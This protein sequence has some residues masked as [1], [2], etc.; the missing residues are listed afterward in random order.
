[1]EIGLALSGGGVRAAAFHLGVLRRLAVEDRFEAVAQISTVSGGSLLI[2]T[3]LAMSNGQWPS[4]S[5]YGRKLFPA[6]RKLLTRTDL[7]SLRAVGW[8]GLMKYNV[9]LVHRRAH[10]LADLLERRWG[11]QGTLRDLWWI[12]ATCLETGKNW[13][14]S[15]REMGDWKFG[16]HYDPRIRI[17]DAAA[18]VGCR[19]LCDW[20]ADAKASPGR[21]VQDR[22]SD[23]ASVGK[24]ATSRNPHSAL[25]WWSL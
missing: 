18:V 6:L 7:L 8:T 16:R 23:P 4:S 10:L 11:V 2:A 20:S 9:R 19:T 14:F 12:N 25:G 24:E 1:M 17:A 13:R 3:L 22:S 5:D 15:K 21:L